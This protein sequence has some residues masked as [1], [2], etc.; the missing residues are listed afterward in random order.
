MFNLNLAHFLTSFST[1]EL[2]ARWTAF[3]VLVPAT[4]PLILVLG[5][6]GYTIQSFKDFQFIMKTG[7][8]IDISITTKDVDQIL[9]VDD[10]DTLRFARVDEPIK[11]H[12]RATPFAHVFANIITKIIE[13]EEN[14]LQQVYELKDFSRTSQA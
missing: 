1:V 5:H 4:K 8:G 2:T 9:V 14:I 12:C 13:K 11:L 7:K 3:G 6:R 10:K